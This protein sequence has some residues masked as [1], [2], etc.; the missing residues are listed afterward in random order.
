MIPV[1][2]DVDGVPPGSRRLSCLLAYDVDGYAEVFA[3]DGVL[4]WPFAPPDWTRRLEGRAAIRA[5]VESNLARS[6]AAGRRLFAL[7]DVML[8][9]AS[10]HS[11]VAEFAV[12]VRASDG[13]STL[14]PYVHVLRLTHDGHIA[15]LRDY[16]GVATAR[17]A[18][19]N[20]SAST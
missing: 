18:Q 19:S 16:F 10:P 15:S 12:E 1:N 2:A 6:K 3:E 7:H 17:L 4:E 9:E 20:D 8:H 13:S 5:H 14:V 11:L